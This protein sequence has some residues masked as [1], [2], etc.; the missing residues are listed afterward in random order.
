MQ[1]TQLTPGVDATLLEHVI[2]ATA[3]AL[4]VLELLTNVV[5]FDSSKESGGTGTGAGAGGCQLKVRSG[6]CQQLDEYR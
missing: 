3:K 1:L 2:T 6:L 4:P 5:D